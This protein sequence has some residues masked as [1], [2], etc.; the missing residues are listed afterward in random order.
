MKHQKLHFILNVACDMRFKWDQK[1]NWI[2]A[3]IKPSLHILYDKN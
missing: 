2:K 1:L 3:A